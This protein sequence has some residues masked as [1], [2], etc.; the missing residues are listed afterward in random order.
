[1]H[2]EEIKEIINRYFGGTISSEEKIVL[3]QWIEDSGDDQAVEALLL[4]CWEHFE[5]QQ[6][7]P[8][9]KADALLKAILQKADR[10]EN[11]SPKSGRFHIQNWMR[12]VAAASIILLMG[13]GCYLFFKHT[14]EKVF[15]NVVTAQ[16]DVMPPKSVNAVL[17]LANGQ[18]IV[19][20]SAANGALAIQGNVNV[21]KSGD[22][23]IAYN[24]NAS[25]STEKEV[26]YNTLSIPRG[27]KILCLTMADGSKVW[28]NSE[29][30]LRY[31]NLFRGKERRVEIT[32]EA[33]FEVSKNTA[34]PFIVNVNNKAEVKVLGTHF[35][36]NAYE[37]EASIR[38][39]L[40][41][42][43][44]KFSSS[45]AASVILSPG[46]QGQLAGPSLK[47]VNAN[48]EETVAWKNDMFNF[49]GENIST[50]MR[51]LARWYDLDVRYEK[52]PTE[53]FYV[54]MSRNTNVSN[55]FKILETTGGVHFEVEGKKI[56]VIR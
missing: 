1:M 25:K 13:V 24:T 56:T 54:K 35:N 34:M 8:A 53:I 50:I 40:L 30:S 26:V 7:I 42:G 38:T 4:K 16:R 48:I 23:Q 27:S 55:V 18:R 15:T 33:Y 5:T 11:H 21:I 12:W 45:P 39:T 49:N 2:T 46:Q 29:S 32:G 14:S 31:P 6:S 17:T 10:Q 9:P 20:D 37:D 3:A 36:I 19:L 44:V 43:S 22:G 51:Q 41:E 52:E 47:V 28:L